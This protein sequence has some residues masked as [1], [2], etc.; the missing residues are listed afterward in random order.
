[1]AMN[2]N[3]I[4]GQNPAQAYQNNQTDASRGTPQDAKQNATT[5]ATK[6]DISP[7]ARQLQ[8]QRTQGQQEAREA[9]T[10][11]DNEQTEQAKTTQRQTSTAHN[12]TRAAAGN[13]NMLNVTA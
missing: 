2:I 12:Q 4:S 13:Q 5:S 8:A 3:A 10:T 6:V 7:K 1:M 9:E 11:A